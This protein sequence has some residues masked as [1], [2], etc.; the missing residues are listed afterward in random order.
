MYCFSL[1]RLNGNALH[2]SLPEE[3]GRLARLQELRLDD[4]PGIGGELPEEWGALAQLQY[5]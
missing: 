5:M 2:G 4:N 1:R 3:W